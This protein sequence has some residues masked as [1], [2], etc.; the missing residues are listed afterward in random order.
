MCS[1][2]AGHPPKQSPCGVDVDRH[3]LAGKT[4]VSFQQAT[5]RM[6]TRLPHY[7]FVTQTLFF[8]VQMFAVQKIPSQS[9]T[10]E[11]VAE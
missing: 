10:Q 1:W 7:G 4:S 6:F 3:R 8:S 5:G 9:C 11:R 2:N